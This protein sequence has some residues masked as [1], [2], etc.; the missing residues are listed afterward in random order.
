VRIATGKSG[1]DNPYG[2]MDR[3]WFTNGLWIDF[4]R[5]I[6]DE[7]FADFHRTPLEFDVLWTAMVAAGAK[8]TEPLAPG[9]AAKAQAF[10]DDLESKHVFIAFDGIASIPQKRVPGATAADPGGAACDG[11][12]PAPD[13]TTSATYA[14]VYAQIEKLKTTG[15]P[16]G[17]EGDALSNP[18]MTP[19]RIASILDFYRPARL[20]LFGDAAAVIGFHQS[21]VNDLD[22]YEVDAIANWFIPWTTPSDFPAHEAEAMPGIERFAASLAQMIDQRLTYTRP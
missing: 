11:H 9:D 17:L 20:V 18:C 19:E 4:S 5:Q 3:T 1:E 6:A 12:D 10:I 7:Y 13:A 2:R 21:G 15:V 14:A 8:V 22:K 16:F